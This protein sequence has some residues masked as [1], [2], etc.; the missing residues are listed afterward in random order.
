MLAAIGAG[1]LRELFASVP[2]QLLEPPIELPPPLGEQELV[3]DLTRLAARN[4]PMGELDCFLGAGVYRR[5]IPA[6]VKGTVSRPEFYTAYTPYQAEASQGTLQTIFE[7]QSMICALTGMDV[8]NASL[9]DGAT[10]TAEGALLAVAHTG[11]RRVLVAGVLHPETL[12]VLR[13]YAEGRSVGIDV[14]GGGGGALVV[15][16]VAAALTDGH[17]AVLTAQPTFLGAIND[18]RPLADT[19]HAAGALLVVAVDPMAAS[20]LVTAGEQGGD[21]AVGEAQQLGIPASYGGPHCG[22]MAVRQPLLRRMPGRLVGMTVD[23]IGRRSYTLTLQ[24]RE[25]HIR[26]ENATSNICTNHALM[27]LAATVYMARMGL[28]GMRAVV[29]V[30]A[31]RTHHLVERLAELPGIEPAL[32]PGAPYLYEAPVR[33]GGDARRFSRALRERGI[34]AGLPLGGLVEGHDDCLLVCC[35]ET[36]SA[37]A[38]ERFVEAAAVVARSRAHQEARA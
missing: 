2:P 25:Q 15:E 16:E 3:E 22:F 7:F 10:A 18:L 35:T 26:R 6:I 36:T 31:R 20:V 28:A 34:L 21:V 24:T 19:A 38:I 30:S 5:F 33:V 17:A 4:R 9:Y 1:S 37:P 14:V 12:R 11:R 23:H 13:T 29:E 8:A 32:P 27:A